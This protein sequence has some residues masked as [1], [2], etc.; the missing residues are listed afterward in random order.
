MQSH[1]VPPTWQTLIS[2]AREQGQSAR[3]LREIL[4]AIG[5]HPDLIDL[6]RITAG[7]IRA[8]GKPGEDSPIDCDPAV[9]REACK[10]IGSLVQQP[11][12]L[13][14]L[15]PKFWA[16]KS[17]RN[18]VL[19]HGVRRYGFPYAALWHAP[20]D[21]DNADDYF[22]LVAQLIS[23]TQQLSGH[24]LL[25]QRYEAFRA[26]RMICQAPELTIP[27]ELQIWD[28]AEVWNSAC[29]IFK[30]SVSK[31]EHAHL[32]A[33]ITR[34]VRYSRGKSPRTRSSSSG[35]KGRSIRQVELEQTHFIAEGSRGFE[36]GDRDDPDQI[37]GSY[38]IFTD[39]QPNI[40][41]DTGLAPNELTDGSEIW[42]V[43]D[44]GVERPFVAD[45]LSQQNVENHIVRSRQ[46][47]PF[48]YNRFTLRELRDLLFG[49]TA[50]FEQCRYQLD[51]TR[52]RA[53]LQLKMEAIAMIHICLWLGQTWTQVI[54]M[55]VVDDENDCEDGLALVIGK[56]GEFCMPVQSPELAGDN[57]WQA[58]SGVR[59]W[60]PRLLLPDLA[61]SSNLIHTL[62]ARFP[63]ISN[64]VF[65]N[66]TEALE[67]EVRNVLRE[68]GKED[69]RFTITK[70]RNYTFLQLI[71]DTH[72]VAAAGLL[73][74]VRV[75]SAQT[76]HYYLQPKAAHL[77]DLYVAS[78]TRV[79]RQV[80]A[81]AGLSYEPP[82]LPPKHPE[83]EAV[84]AT[85]CL[86]PETIASNVKA[87]AA[88]VRKRS[89]VEPAKRV[90]W[91]N[92]YTLWTVSMF[93][94][95][96]ACRA[97]RNP[98]RLVAEFDPRLHLGAIADKDGEDRHM[99]RL[100]CVPEILKRQLAE[101]FSHCTLVSR[102]LKL[103]A[104]EAEDR[105]SKGFF[106]AISNTGIHRVH[107]RPATI[108]QQMEQ[109]PGYVPHRINAYRKYLRTELF[110]R[111]VH[112]ETLNALMGHWLR[113]EEPQD[114]YSTFCPASYSMMIGDRISG[115]LKSLGWYCQS[116]RWST[117]K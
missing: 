16:N 8:L 75:P 80:Y 71:N 109:V 24:D 90:A 11:L 48:T 10:W 84:G 97:I 46:Q 76:P 77:R 81:C 101:Y 40:D 58:E 111:G 29:E 64:Q 3:T 82:Q 65:T 37:A 95:S 57:R 22:R 107:I 106:L 6:P 103:P 20:R 115:L 44:D 100:A 36:L 116:S 94:M 59:E 92:A 79:L 23:A 45:L 50:L 13:E 62:L 117:S 25:G 85:H 43:D 99:S 41:E 72:D 108:Y 28:D 30:P 4:T 14:R 21:K 5:A 2:L 39:P 53:G 96:T 61:G 68:L 51:H 60:R 91:H 9:W 104:F 78:L 66:K 12:A 27:A 55:M 69:P 32:Y 93:M 33:S 112:A 18:P 102:K 38:E 17:A 47:V 7:L 1:S 89:G 54:Q 42:L 88:I 114:K 74:G 52:N 56:P 34:L 35:G 70:V 73:S 31:S 63:R 86:L 83:G 19:N 110:E 26:L 49:A 98:L 15:G 113:G 67:R 87:L 105:W